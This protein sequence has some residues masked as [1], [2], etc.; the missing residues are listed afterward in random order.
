MKE[1]PFY[2]YNFQER[3]ERQRVG[4]KGASLIE[5]HQLGL[6]VPPAFIIPVGYKYGESFEEELDEG[7]SFLEKKTGLKFGSRIDPLL[8]SVR[9]GAPIS[10]PGM[11][12]T[13]LNVGLVEGAKSSHLRCL[14]FGGMKARLEDAFRDSVGIPLP[15]SPTEQLISAI[16]SV[17][18]SWFS[19][20]ARSYRDIMGIEGSGTAVSVQAMVY[21]NAGDSSGTSVLFSRD[22]GTGQN[23]IT[24]EWSPNRQGEVLVGGEAGGSDILSIQSMQ[25]HI[26]VEIRTAIARLESFYR[27]VVEVEVTIQEGVVWFLQVRTAILTPEAEARTTIDMWKEGLID[28]VDCLR[29]LRGLDLS[30][31]SYRPA[32]DASRNDVTDVLARGIPVENGIVSGVSLAS[33]AFSSPSVDGVLFATTTSPSDIQAISNARAVV[34]ELGGSTSHAAVVC[35]GLGIP[36]VV[37]CGVGALMPHTGRSVVVDSDLGI[38]SFG[39]RERNDSSSVSETASEVMDVINYLESTELE[40]AYNED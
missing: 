15:N 32:S 3:P 26:L 38:V 34:T 35:R 8:V 11:M 1:S 10:M 30:K 18:S 9:S 2:L 25:H 27:K 28:P 7:V 20:R 36:A 14:N 33:E 23:V 21:G 22:P 31:I 39:E 5:M 13:I 29:R 19:E 17:D 40:R 37:G 24:G 12:D 4:N 6:N 16:N